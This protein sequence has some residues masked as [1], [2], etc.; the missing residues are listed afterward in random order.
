MREI[1]VY[2]A[3]YGGQGS[4][5]RVHGTSRNKTVFCCCV[6]YC[7]YCSSSFPVCVVICVGAV[8]GVVVSV[9]VVFLVVG[10]VVLVVVGR[11]LFQDLRSSK[12]QDLYPK[13][14]D[15]TIQ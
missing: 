6:C 4:G 1:R 15:L 13:T 12:T 11:G 7:L 9:F 2:A 10:F 3:E 5:L 14:Q 8:V